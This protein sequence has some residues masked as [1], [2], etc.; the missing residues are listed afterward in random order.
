MQCSGLDALGCNL[1]KVSG[2][3]LA[4]LCMS[5]GPRPHRCTPHQSQQENKSVSSVILFRE[6]Q[7][8][9][10]PILEPISRARG[11]GTLL[12]GCYSSEPT[13]GIGGC[14]SPT[15]AKWLPYKGKQVRQILDKI[16]LT[17][18]E[19]QNAYFSTIPAKGLGEGE[20]SIGRIPL[21]DISLRL[22]QGSLN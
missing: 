19:G 5:A 22:I 17:F 16:I 10:L 9:L 1:I 15:Q 13:S 6:D 3:L 21:A 12:I 7:L 20:V 18:T 4:L 11:T 2:I 8:R 14:I